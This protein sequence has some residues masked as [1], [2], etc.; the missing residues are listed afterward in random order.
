VLRGDFVRCYG[1]LRDEPDQL[2]FEASSV[3]LRRADGSTIRMRPFEDDGANGE[4]LTF[5]LPGEGLDWQSWFVVV[6]RRPQKLW[7]MQADDDTTAVFSA[8]P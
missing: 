7:I 6:S 1:S 5:T 2:H 8:L 4:L 3:E